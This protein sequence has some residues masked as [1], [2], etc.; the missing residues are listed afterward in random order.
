[1]DK[2]D[3]PNNPVFWFFFPIGM[4]LTKEG[5][6]PAE[7][8]DFYEMTYEVWDRELSVY[9]SHKYLPNAIEEAIELNLKYC[10]VYESLSGTYLRPYNNW[11]DDWYEQ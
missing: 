6:G 9:G 8:D 10:D 11:K 4:P 1:M 5:Y 7:S 2:R 3:L